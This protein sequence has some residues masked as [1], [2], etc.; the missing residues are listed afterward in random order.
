MTILQT[1]RRPLVIA[2]PEKYTSSINT[3]YQRYQA[4]KWIIEEARSNGDKHFISKTVKH[5]PNL[6]SGN[7]KANLQK[8]SRWWYQR[9]VTMDLKNGGRCGVLTATT[10]R[11]LKRAM[12][13]SLVGGERKPSKW[14]AALYPVFCQDF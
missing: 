10:S 11:G 8:T 7:E 13:K 6:F 2:S 12:F 14:A 4:T 9:Q 3:I 1:L 5:F